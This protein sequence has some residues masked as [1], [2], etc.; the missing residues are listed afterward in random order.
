MTVGA[1]TGLEVDQE[2]EL[3]EPVLEC[4]PGGA[5]CHHCEAIACQECQHSKTP[6][7]MP[8]GVHS[9]SSLAIPVGNQSDA[10]DN[11]QFR[12]HT[13]YHSLTYHLE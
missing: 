11:P 7:S 12:D 6:A 5:L 1:A 3:R 10:G 4:P 2:P 8:R 9:Y 13:H